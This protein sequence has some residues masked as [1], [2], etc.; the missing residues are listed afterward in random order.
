MH[1]I[2]KN[3]KI[4]LYKTKKET[5][6]QERILEKKGYVVSNKKKNLKKKEKNTVERKNLNQGTLKKKAE[7]K[8]I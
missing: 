7:K 5:K 6:T 4:K 8:I 1:C 3:V 2:K